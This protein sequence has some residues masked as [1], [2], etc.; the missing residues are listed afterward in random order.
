MTLKD[1]CEIAV[2]CNLTSTAEAYLNV[3][4]HAISIFSDDKLE[5]EV[6][7]LLGELN[8]VGGMPIAEYMKRFKEE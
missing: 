1:A 7:E 8:E 5:D 6:D 4:L 2:A 3:R